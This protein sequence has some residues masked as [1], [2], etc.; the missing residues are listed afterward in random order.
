MIIQDLSKPFTVNIGRLTKDHVSI[1]LNYG[2]TLEVVKM[3]FHD[4]EDLECGLTDLMHTVNVY[5]REKYEHM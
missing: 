4:L 2:D 1:V 5:L 3:S